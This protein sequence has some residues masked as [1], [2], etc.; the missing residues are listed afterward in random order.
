VAQCDEELWR[1]HLQNARWFQGKGLPF[2]G[3]SIE[4]LPWC[5][6]SGD[7]WVRSELAIVHAGDSES[8][9]HLLV[10][11]SL[12]GM[13]EPEAVV[14]QIDL[15]GR[16]VV[17][18]V[19]VPRSPLAMRVLLTWLA[20][21][22][23]GDGPHSYTAAAN[24]ERVCLGGPTDSQMNPSEDTTDSREFSFKDPTD[25]ITWFEAPP[26]PDSAIMIFEGEQSNT[27]VVIGDSVLFKIFRK[28]SPGPN[29]ECEVM[30]ALASCSIIPR[31]IGRWSAP[32]KTYDLGIFVQRIPDAQDGWAY[33]LEACGNGVSIA[34]EMEK[35]GETLHSLHANL[36]E[37]F[38]TSTIDSGRVSAQM[39]DRL[40][41]ACDQLPELAAHRDDLR[42]ILTLP[43][44]EIHIQRIHGDFHLGQAL[45]SPAGWTII[46]FE[47][48]PLK[49]PEERAAPDS[50]W[51]DVAG[52][53]R[54]LDYARSTHPHPESS[55]A[56]E[57]YDEART[58]FLRGYLSSGTLPSAL[59]TA[60][61]VDKAI[62]ELV[63][64][65]RNRPT[66]ADIPRHAI[67]S[68]LSSPST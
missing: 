44:S 7:V 42:G 43:P 39:L 19:D 28:L 16:G 58:A 11:Y 30:R 62:Y 2:R 64:E 48:E 46:D 31:L 20:G 12:P 67:T 35:L 15:P 9:Y 24:S 18:V 34:D 51:R 66:W 57:W 17:D 50:V 40:D 49:T 54:S 41:T 13:C 38:P 3:M 59:L 63:Y 22:T 68:A 6:S 21:R 52:L 65:V 33:A 36:A 5:V 14:G 27:T 60:Y 53:L 55:S 37:V 4:P 26:D 45:I 25:W 61:E 32:E 23:S 56:Y 8:V 10:A 1:D 47:G 29:L